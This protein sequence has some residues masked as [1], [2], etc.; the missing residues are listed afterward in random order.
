MYKSITTLLGNVSSQPINKY[1]QPL[2]FL[3]YAVVCF[4]CLI[5]AL[6]IYDGG[7]E[8]KTGDWLINY[9]GGFVRRGL[10][11]QIIFE[12]SGLGLNILWTAFAIQATVY[13][14]VAYYTLEFFFEQERSAAS[15]LLLAS[16]A[17][18]FLFPIYDT[19]GALKKEILVFLAFCLLMRSQQNGRI[20]H[21][22]ALSSLAIY[23]IAAFSHEPCVL[24]IP[25]FIYPLLQNYRKQTEKRTRILYAA[26]FLIASA[27]S[28]L[29]AIA[30]P[31][32]AY[33]YK[34]ICNSL[35]RA[36][37]SDPICSG[38]IVWIKHTMNDGVNRVLNFLKIYSYVYPLS[39]ALAIIPIAIT[40]WFR[41]NLLI[42]IIGF[43]SLLPL[44]LVAYDWGR[45][46]HI[47]IFFITTLALNQPAGLTFHA[48]KIPWVSIPIYATAWYLPACCQPSFLG[49]FFSSVHY[50]FKY[51]IFV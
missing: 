11:G 51:Y 21:S 15:L 14:L 40:D 46:I 27:V 34:H 23:V 16:P 2:S 12:L 22:L 42:V 50:F 37:L 13:L 43:L 4:T 38:S 20:S 45:W 10:I 26:M 39:F 29:C 17:F 35:V 25:F 7:Q 33:T 5:Y 19:S 30:F 28:L 9:E 18:I 8:W 6:E 36:G 49:G 41:R 24:T 1:R 47:Y 3:I 32:D 44:F 31:G 48:K